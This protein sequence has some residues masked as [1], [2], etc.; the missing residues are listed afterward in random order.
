MAQSQRPEDEIEE[1]YKNR[2]QHMCKHYTIAQAYG[3]NTHTVYAL[4][5]M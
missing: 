2:E 4:I 5:Q 3:A 1:T